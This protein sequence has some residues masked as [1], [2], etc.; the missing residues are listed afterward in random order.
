M[1]IFGVNEMYGILQGNQI[2]IMFISQTKHQRIS[3]SS[4]KSNTT[5][6]TPFRFFRKTASNT[7]D[8]RARAITKTSNQRSSKQGI[9]RNDVMLA[10]YPLRSSCSCLF[11]NASSSVAFVTFAAVSSTSARSAAAV[12]AA[13]C[14]YNV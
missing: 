10:E 1:Y 4:V 5:V 2:I 9:E 11:R 14:K 8:K 3:Q 12:A 7:T 13:A 6:Q